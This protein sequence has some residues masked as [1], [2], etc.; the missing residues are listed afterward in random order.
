MITIHTSPSQYTPSDNCIKWCIS[1]SD[2]GSGGI[3]KRM[4]YQLVLSDGTPITAVESIR[5]PQADDIV[6]FDFQA[7]VRGLLSTIFPLVDTPAAQED[8]YIIKGVKLKYWEVETD[9][10]ACE[11]V[12][13]VSSFS[14]EVFVYRGV[15]QIYEEN[16]TGARM[17]HHY[18][19]NITMCRGARAFIW[20]LRA[21]YSGS[22]SATY[23]WRDG[24]TEDITINVPSG[25][26]ASVLPL[27][28]QPFTGTN[29]T[30]LTVSVPVINKTITIEYKDCCCSS[31]DYMN[32]MYLDPMGGRGMMSFECAD[33][34]SLST[35]GGVVCLYQECG[36]GTLGD[37]SDQYTRSGKSLFGKTAKE[38]I[39][40]TREA[41]YSK[42]EME[43]FKSFLASTEYHVQMSYDANTN[44]RSFIVESGTAVYYDKEEAVEFIVKG[45]FAE[46][47]RTL[48]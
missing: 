40:M 28:Y 36:Q 21:G 8:E 6:C 41:A 12:E 17:L 29:P 1:Q 24:V 31:E 30:W 26:E 16:T 4:A 37:G 18:P 44:F 19:D 45:Y 47:Y 10:L 11:T 2:I 20:L 14:D 7:D 42:A 22:L 3:V 13:G 5:T 23:S 38:V 48:R 46:N 33:E 39:T 27:H 43:Y 15:L 9:T 35:D 25:H 34:F 32:I